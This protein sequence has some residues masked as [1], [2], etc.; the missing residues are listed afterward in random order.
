MVRLWW[1]HASLDSN[2]AWCAAAAAQLRYKELTSVCVKANKITPSVKGDTGYTTTNMGSD[3]E[4][5]F[6]TGYITIHNDTISILGTKAQSND[7]ETFGIGSIGTSVSVDLQHAEQMVEQT[8]LHHTGHKFT[9][10]LPFVANTRHVMS[11]L[12][13]SPPHIL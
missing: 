11:Q 13:L 6:P 3:H 7:L 9:P 8:F 5:V 12:V 1:L 4:C 2:A 10:R